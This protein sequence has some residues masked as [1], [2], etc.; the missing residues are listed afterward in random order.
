MCEAVGCAAGAWQV[1]ERGEELAAVRE[2]MAQ[3]TAR[4]AIVILHI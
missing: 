1:E 3:Q 2:E 4:Y